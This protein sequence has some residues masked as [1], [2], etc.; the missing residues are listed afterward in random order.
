MAIC[1]VAAAASFCEGKQPCDALSSPDRLEALRAA[2]QDGTDIAPLGEDARHWVFPGW[3]EP[4]LRINNWTIE[5]LWFFGLAEQCAGNGERILTGSR[6]RPLICR[7]SRSVSTMHP[8][9]TD[10][11]ASAMAPGSPSSV[12]WRVVTKRAAVETAA[13]SLR[14][15]HVAEM[16][17]LLE[18]QIRCIGRG[19]MNR[20]R[21]YE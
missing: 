3:R 6:A 19:E 10:Q 11:R 16:A 14:N 5:A 9:S 4:Q 8:S 20:H 18:H 12:A 15:L 13:D 21:A 2:V 17:R 7:P 1:C